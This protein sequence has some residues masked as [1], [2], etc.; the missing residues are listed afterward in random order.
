MAKAD[1]LKYV[2]PALTKVMPPVNWRKTK[3]NGHDFGDHYNRV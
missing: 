2:L 3:I 1:V